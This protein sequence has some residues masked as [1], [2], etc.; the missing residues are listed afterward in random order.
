MPMTLAQLLLGK[1]AEEC[2]EV[3]QR[4]LK[5]QQFGLLEYQS[6]DHP[7]NSERLWQEWLDLTSVMEIVFGTARPHKDDADHLAQKR[8]RLR[9][10]IDY[11][12]ALGLVAP[13]TP[14]EGDDRYLTIPSEWITAEGHPADSQDGRP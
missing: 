3:A 2:A 5:A 10:Y 7:T 13:Y 14:G 11:S 1:I 12:Y 6:T 4:A 9:Q 8:Q